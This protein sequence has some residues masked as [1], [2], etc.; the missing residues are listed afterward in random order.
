MDQPEKRHKRSRR[1]RGQQ[2]PQ[3]PSKRQRRQ[4]PQEQHSLD[5]L[6]PEVLEMVL[7]LLPYQE[8]ANTLRLVSKR[9]CSV[10]TTILNNAFLSAGGRLNS[11]L[12]HLALS[13][14]RAANECELV[15]SGR[16][17]NSLELVRAQYDL[18]RAVCWRYTHPPR[19]QR[20]GRL[21]FY[22]GLILDELDALLDKAQKSPGDL[23]D[24][25]GPAPCVTQFGVM[26]KA[27]M[28]LFEKVSERKVNSRNSV[29]SGC[30]PVDLLDCLMTG[31]ELLKLRVSSGR[32]H[33]S[34]LVSMKLRYVLK[35]AWF[36]CL[37]VPGRDDSAE[38]EECWRDQQRFMYLRLRRLVGSSNEHHLE[39]VHFERERLMTQTTNDLL[40]PPKIP[41]CST[42]SGYGEYAGRFFYYGNMN[43]YAFDSKIM[44]AWRRN[45]IRD[46]IRKRASDRKPCYDL[47]INVELKC[48]PELAPLAVRS[49]LKC[50]DFENQSNV[51]THRPY[52]Y[53][54]L[55]ISCPASVSNKLPGQF[56]WELRSPRRHRGR[57]HSVSDNS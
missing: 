35:R 51:E 27:F 56:V 57:H 23:L 36:T 26:C 5:S 4:A 14:E 53:L 45:T 2:Q 7:R 32:R 49:L 41:A 44:D 50:D 43:E 9:C 48:S 18:L 33:D 11:A 3:R 8:L 31:R 16:A 20:F 17:H 10:A 29:S 30:K 47:L 13:T 22:G 38:N 6:P 39:A 46:R 1:R 25:E 54:K 24:K 28:N 40:P 19:T 55:S 21:C 52:L 12:R 37:E 42:Y 15:L 34:C